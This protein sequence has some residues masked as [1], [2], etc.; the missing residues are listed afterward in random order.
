M[1]DVLC[2]PGGPLD[3]PADDEPDRV[4]LRNCAAVH[5]RGQAVQEDQKRRVLDAPGDR[6]A[7]QGMA[8]IAVGTPVPDGAA[9]LFI[10]K[11][12]I[13]SGVTNWTGRMPRGN[14]HRT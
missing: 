11:E 6:E 5:Q 14:S 1:P 10:L 7:E 8:A 3:P 9:T 2:V 12:E 4:D 13:E